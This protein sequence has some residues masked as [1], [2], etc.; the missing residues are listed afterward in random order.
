MIRIILSYLNYYVTRLPTWG[1]YVKTCRIFFAWVD[2]VD[3]ASYSFKNCAMAGFFWATFV[4][5]CVPDTIKSIY[6]CGWYVCSPFFE[7]KFLL[8]PS[9]KTF[10]EK[11]KF[12]KSFQ[13]I[14]SLTRIFRSPLNEKCRQ[15]CTRLD[16]VVAV[17]SKS[18]FCTSASYEM[19]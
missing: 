13:I 11:L 12:R 18:L 5:F 4:C 8:F 15:I 6:R 10:Q 1:H 9:T 19:L 7:K 16:I 14:K 2:N 17:D 3:I